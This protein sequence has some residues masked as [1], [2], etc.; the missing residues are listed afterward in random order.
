MEIKPTS[1]PVKDLQAGPGRHWNVECR[2]INR[3]YQTFPNQKGNAM[4]QGGTL[5]VKAKQKDIKMYEK[6]NPSRK[7]IFTTN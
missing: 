5:Q 1:Q 4:M 6:I 2:S 7:W 3:F